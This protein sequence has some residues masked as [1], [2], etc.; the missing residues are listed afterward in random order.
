MLNAATAIL[1]TAGTLAALAIIAT[2]IYHDR[3]VPPPLTIALI[4]L[5]AIGYAVIR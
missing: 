2:L 1:W 5:S 3:D 4:T